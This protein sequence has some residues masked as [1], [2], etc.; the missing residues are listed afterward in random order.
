MQCVGHK[1]KFFFLPTVF[2]ANICI[3]T[4]TFF[5]EFKTYAGL[6]SSING[7]LLIESDSVM[8]SLVSL[9]PYMQKLSLLGSM[10][11]FTNPS[12][13]FGLRVGS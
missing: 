10:F 3:H 7:V 4:V 8:G 12:G 9:L 1:G 13:L 2:S 5:G 6:W 11:A